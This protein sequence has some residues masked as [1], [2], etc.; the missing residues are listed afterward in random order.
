MWLV[1]EAEAVVHAL[2]TGADLE[3]ELEARREA[4]RGFVTFHQ[5]PVNHL[6]DA[7]EGSSP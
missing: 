1:A 7:T 6:P 3:L 2:R 4:R 5:L